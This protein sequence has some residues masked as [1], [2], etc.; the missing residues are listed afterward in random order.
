MKA[1]KTTTKAT[2]QAHQYRTSEGGLLYPVQLKDVPAQG[3]GWG[4]VSGTALVVDLFSW[5]DAMPANQAGYN[6]TEFV[7]SLMEDAA[8]EL[9]ATAEDF[10]DD[11][12]GVA[13]GM[14]EG[15]AELVA[16]A[17]QSNDAREH[18]AAHLSNLVKMHEVMNA[19]ELAKEKAKALD[20]HVLALAKGGPRHE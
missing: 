3:Y 11:H 9:D 15:F 5:R 2:K 14:L 7:R 19:E 18:M 1:V 20:V 8:K 4:N 13:V 6:V 10:K 17:L 16:Y 12:R